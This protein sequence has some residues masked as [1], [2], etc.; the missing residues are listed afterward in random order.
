M[1]FVLFS[2]IAIEAVNMLFEALKG[3]VAVLELELG[4]CSADGRVA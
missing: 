1:F 3:R 2:R 4:S